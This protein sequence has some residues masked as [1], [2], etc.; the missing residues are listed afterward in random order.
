M[1][2]DGTRPPRSRIVDIARA[3]GVSTATVDRVLHG[4]LRVRAATAQRV[5]KSAAALEYLPEAELCRALQPAPME[6]VFLLPAGT[7]RFL[8]QLGDQIRA[9]GPALAPYNVQCRVV[10]I[11]SFDPASVATALLRHGRKAQA[12]AFMALEHPRVR[13]AVAQ[14][15]EH[16][17]HVVTL[18]SDLTQ[19][20]REAYV[21]MDNRAAGRTAALLIG[22]F[23]AGRE[24]PVAMIAGSLSYRG[25][26]EREMGFLRLIE[27]EFPILRVVG[28]REGLDDA[29]TNY[30]LARVLLRQHPNLVAL[31]NIGGGAEG[32]GRALK[33]HRAAMRPVFVAHGLTPETRALLI[34]GTLDALINQDPQTMIVDCVR[35]FTNLRDGRRAL[36]GV[37]PVRISIVLRENL[38]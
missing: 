17:V 9:S 30:K 21:G 37:E 8:R 22:R 28:V 1:D 35:I 19:S 34:D 23:L 13:E 27:D 15:A 16:G 4:R 7:N 33:E 6:I 36:A 25:H 18:I 5:I 38:P 29:E 20:R 10:F 14:L 11:D 31:Y 26:E 12:L 32:V 24:G 3:A 2:S